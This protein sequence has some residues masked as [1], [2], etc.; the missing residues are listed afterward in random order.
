MLHQPFTWLAFTNEAGNSRQKLILVASTKPETLEGKTGEISLT[1]LN[2]F[3]CLMYW[4]KS[5][6]LTEERLLW[7]FI[8]LEEKN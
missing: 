3:Q 7:I 6:P 5:K 4:N 2:V 1:S 8:L